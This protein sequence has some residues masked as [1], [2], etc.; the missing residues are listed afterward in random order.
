VGKQPCVSHD[1]SL[2]NARKR[3]HLPMKFTTGAGDPKRSPSARSAT[4]AGTQAHHPPD[5]A[6]GM[7]PLLLLLLLVLASL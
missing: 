3:H 2:P 7:L 5:H 4:A 6:Q 1:G